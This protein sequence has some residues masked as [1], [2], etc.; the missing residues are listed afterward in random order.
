MER[1]MKN[2]FILILCLQ[3]TT[4][5]TNGQDFKKTAPAINLENGDTFVFIGNSI[6][7]QCL[8]TQYVED[9]YYTRY[10][11]KRI[12]FHNAGVSGDVAVDVLNR[13]DKDIAEYNPKYASVLIGMNDGRYQRMNDEI[14]DDYTAGMLG[15]VDSL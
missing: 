11:N 1:L 10:P 15:I 2:L 4:N 7:H 12:T 6:T 8:Y 5:L 9:Y 14:L 3:I 13:F